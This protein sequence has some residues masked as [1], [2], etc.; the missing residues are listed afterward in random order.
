MESIGAEAHHLVNL[1]SRI[2]LFFGIAGVV[3]PFLQR[4]KIS[5]ILSYLLCGIIIGPHGLASLS[6]TYPWLDYFTIENTTTVQMLGELGIITLMFMIG[7]ELSL[8]RLREMKLYIFGLGSVQ[9]I[10]TG[11]AIY[12]VARYFNNSIEASI[13]LGASFALSST[14]IVVQLLEERHLSNRPIGIL[15]F[16]VLLMQDLAVVPILLLVASFTPNDSHNIIGALVTSLLIGGLGIFV[17]FMMGKLLLRPLLVSISLTRNPEW[18][19]DFTVFITIAFAVITN[20]AGLSLALGAFL[21]G[22]LIAETEFRHEVNIIVSPLRGILL[23][24]FFLSIGMIINV[25][26]IFNHPLM[27]LLSVV[28]ICLLKS[29]ILFILCLGLKI[30]GKQAIE[31]SIYL[32]Q[33]G[34]FALLILGVAFTA[35][36]MDVHDVQF[37]LLVTVIAM[38]VTPLLFKL[39]PIIGRYTSH[40]FEDRPLK[41]DPPLAEEPF[42]IIAGLGQVGEL[43]AKVL[44]E[45]KISYIAFDHYAERVQTLKKKGFN[46]IYGDARKIELWHR[47]QNKNVIAAI[48][49]IDDYKA[50]HRIL[51]SLLAQWPLLPIIVRSEDFS[52]IKEL[53]DLGA[54]HVVS[55]TLESSLAIIHALMKQLG[56]DPNSIDEILKKIRKKN[57]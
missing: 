7:L 13:L 50:T 21:A 23:G 19:A 32:A 38:M 34:E 51:K 14:A 3:V 37:F 30:P 47:L 41:I 26:E 33:P 55:E 42:I 11:F 25:S 9:I 45:Q 16:S 31:A 8:N 43:I 10:S 48:I 15:C 53:Y 36:I 35:N 44:E 17:A 49:A 4:F 40:Y 27:L 20:M 12:F 46:V 57:V 22:L 6:S 54:I 1:L 28:G 39:A 56:S 24:I 5:S 18:L 29:I 52:V 2:L